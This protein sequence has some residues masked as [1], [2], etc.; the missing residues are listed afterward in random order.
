[1]AAASCSKPPAPGCSCAWLAGSGAE[2]GEP[3]DRRG[4]MAGAWGVVGSAAAGRGLSRAAAVVGV[5]PIV[6]LP[7]GAPPLAVAAV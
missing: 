2:A 5:L 6:V 4:G 3:M 1:M 7:V